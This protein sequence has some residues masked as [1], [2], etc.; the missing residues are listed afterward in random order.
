MVAKRSYI[1]DRGDIVWLDFNP[2][3]GHEQ[4]GRRP[5]LVVSSGKYNAKSGLALVC[6][7]TSHPK[8]YPFEVEFVARVAQ[9]VIL[10]DQVRGIDWKQRKAEKI[11]VV[12]ESVVTEVQEYIKKLIIDVTI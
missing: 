7:V 5:A 12:S 1:P 9:G 11:G 2:I 3:R 8:G 6:P 4:G 10:A